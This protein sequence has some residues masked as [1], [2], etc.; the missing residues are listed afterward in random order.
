MYDLVV[1]STVRDSTVCIFS[2][3]HKL[4]YP[5]Y[6][7]VWKSHKLS[8]TDENQ[9]MKLAS[10]LPRFSRHL[11]QLLGYCFRKVW[12]ACVWKKT[13]LE[14]VSSLPEEETLL[15]LFSIFHSCDYSLMEIR[16]WNVNYWKIGDWQAQRQMEIRK[17]LGCVFFLLFWIEWGTVNYDTIFWVLWIILKIKI[18]GV[19]H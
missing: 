12:K 16:N 13:V 1:W 2:A 5:F 14:W 4:F 17:L 3:I 7:Y 18:Q 6:Y 19:P 15:P 9:G 10:L 11:L 8:L